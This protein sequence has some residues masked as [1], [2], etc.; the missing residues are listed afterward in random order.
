MVESQFALALTVEEMVALQTRYPGNQ[1]GTVDFLQFAEAL[2]KT[3]QYGLDRTRG[4]FNFLPASKG[5]RDLQGLERDMRQKIT[6]RLHLA[7]NYQYQSAY[8]MLCDANYQLAGGM[9]REDLK[10]RVSELLGVEINDREVDALFSKYK[11]ANGLVDVRSM[12]RRLLQPAPED[13]WFML[14]AQLRAD[15]CKEAETR[16][17]ESARFKHTPGV[18]AQDPVPTNEEFPASL[19]GFKWDVNK[20]VQKLK[21]KINEHAQGHAGYL[22]LA[23]CKIFRHE[24]PERK[25]DMITAREFRDVVRAKFSLVCDEQ[26]VTAAHATFSLVCDEQECIDL[27]EML[28][29]G[30]GGSMPITELVRRLV[31]RDYIERSWFSTRDSTD[32]P[33]YEHGKPDK[34][35]LQ[36]QEMNKHNWTVDIL[37]DKIR[38]KLHERSGGTGNL[39]QVQATYRLFLDGRNNGVTRERFKAHLHDKFAILLT[40]DEVDALFRRHDPENT[41]QLDLYK[42]VMRLVGVQAPPEPWFQGR[43]SY[44]FRCGRRAPHKEDLMGAP[45]WKR[46][47]WSLHHLE[48]ELIKKMW[49]KSNQDGGRFAFKSAV[50]LLRSANPDH[51]DRTSFTRAAAKMVVFRQFDIVMDDEWMVVFRQFDIVM[52]DELVDQLFAKYAD[53]RTD[54]ISIHKLVRTLLPPA[55]DGSHHLVPKTSAQQAATKTLLHKVFEMTGKR[56]DIVNLNGAGKFNTMMSSSGVGATYEMPARAEEYDLSTLEVLANRGGRPLDDEAVRSLEAAVTEARAGGAYGNTCFSGASTL[57]QSQQA[58]KR[59]GSLGMAS[60][61]Q[62]EFADAPPPQPPPLNAPPLSTPSSSSSSSSAQPPQCSP[63]PQWT[64]ASQ[65]QHGSAASGGGDVPAAP[66]D[67][68]Q[69]AA[70]HAWI[71]ELVRQMQVMRRQLCSALMSSLIWPSTAAAH[72]AAQHQPPQRQSA[73]P[74]TST[75]LSNPA[76]PAANQNALVQERPLRHQMTVSDLQLGGDAQRAKDGSAAAAAAAAAAPATDPNRHHREAL[77]KMIKIRLRVT[78]GETGGACAPEQQI[79]ITRREDREAWLCPL[80]QPPPEGLLDEEEEEDSLYDDCSEPSSVFDCEDLSSSIEELRVG[81]TSW[82]P[83]SAKCFLSEAEQKAIVDANNREDVGVFSCSPAPDTSGQHPFHFRTDQFFS[84]EFQL[85]QL[86][87]ASA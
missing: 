21:C 73:L 76:V 47:K 54:K 65:G 22:F 83:V 1:P 10:L 5:N 67:A 79:I 50:N 56:R 28:E 44:D 36:A 13:G 46:T 86:L 52:D 24:L 20:L 68:Q 55:F 32:M 33:G 30:C 70:Y 8:R 84:S 2:S 23:A 42:F 15:A 64:G 53:P 80:P 61:L 71:A 87:S 59:N 11:G 37:E 12:V 58:R 39:Y 38:E 40:D 41:G 25:G 74:P 45:E 48:Q 77:D 51:L 57:V 16:I 66:S 7:G 81:L 14:S 49:A 35:V 69:Q 85:D 6:D 75:D 78:Q 29:P 31:P 3:P 27:F 60:L 9:G 4:C 72:R 17:S 18:V 43:E 82:S 63:N 34:V 62:P 19:R 26:G